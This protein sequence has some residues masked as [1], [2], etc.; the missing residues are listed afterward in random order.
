MEQL[1]VP[2]FQQTNRVVPQSVSVGAD[3]D[4]L[5][6]W[7]SASLRAPEQLPSHLP[8]PAWLRHTAIVQDCRPLESCTQLQDP[9]GSS[10][11]DSI[12]SSGT[13]A[14]IVGHGRSGS[15]G[16]SSSSSPQHSDCSSSECSSVAAWVRVQ[17]I[18]ITGS[19]DAASVHSQHKYCADSDNISAGGSDSQ[20]CIAASTSDVSKSARVQGGL[21]SRLFGSSKR[22]QQEPA[23]REMGMRARLAVLQSME[24]H[25]I[26]VVFPRLVLGTG[27]LPAGI[28]LSLTCIVLAGRVQ[29]IC[30]HM[31][32]QA[33]Q[34][35]LAHP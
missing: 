31:A 21:V 33:H 13:G 25:R 3:G 14:G 32:E 11:G 22:K 12:R 2:C 30:R 18:G 4:H 10:C 1:V 8:K 6:S 29:S 24:W 28:I 27:G 16:G 20:C 35:M 7:A 26:D 23:V 9:A 17:T 5:V 34:S 15:S 19:K